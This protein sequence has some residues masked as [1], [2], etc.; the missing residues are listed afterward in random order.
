[1]S[2]KLILIP[3]ILLIVIAIT[4]QLVN[5]TP[6]SGDR[7][8]G[9]EIGTVPDSDVKLPFGLNQTFTIVATV[10]FIS[11]FALITILGVLAG[12]KVEVLGSTIQLSDYSQKVIY[13]ALTYLGIWG[14]FSVL[15]TVGLG[16]IGGIFSIPILGLFGYV[17]LTLLYV[18]GIVQEINGS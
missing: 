3:L 17:F 18:T 11:L 13:N 8:G 10:G 14:I 4:V 9:T 15:S 5:L 2:N 1:M 12:T 16:G 6:I 7:T